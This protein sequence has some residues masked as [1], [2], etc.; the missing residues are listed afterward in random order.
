MNEIAPISEAEVKTLAIDWYEK[1]TEKVP[2][3]QYISL[4]SEKN[5]RME[6]PNGDI[7]VEW[8][9]FQNWYEQV[10]NTFFDQTHILKHLEVKPVSD[11]AEVKIVVYWEAS[12]WQPPAP[13][14]Q[15][16]MLDAYQNWV[17]QRSLTTQL[18]VIQTYVVDRF[19]YAADSARL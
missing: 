15:R 14:S 18:P 13:K 8:N 19:D 12:M 2:R 9:G 3:N 11:C 6:F 5:L 17:V 1:L 4:L 16:I 7:F 10:T